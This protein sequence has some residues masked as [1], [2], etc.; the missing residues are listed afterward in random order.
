M[1]K[2]KIT[3]ML[4]LLLSLSSFACT[5]YAD[6][7]Q[8]AFLKDMSE[9]LAKRWSYDENEDSMTRQEFVEY[10][11]KLVDEEYSRLNKY[12]DEEF[13]D[14]KFNILAHAYIDAINTQKES[15]NYYNDIEALYDIEWQSGY[16]IRAL[17]IPTFFDSYGLIADEETVKEF[18]GGI[19][20]SIDLSSQSNTISSTNTEFEIYNNEGITVYVTGTETTEYSKIINLRIQNLN[21][22]DLNIMTKDAQLVINGNMISSSLYAEVKSGKIS[23][24]KIELYND[25]LKNAGIDKLTDISFDLI[26][27]DSSTYDTLFT[28]DQI[29]LT[30]DDEDNISARTVYTDKETIRQVQE[31]LNSA[32]YDC[33]SA[34]GVPGKKTNSAILQFERDHG[35]KENTDITP[36]LLLVLQECIQE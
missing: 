34:D 30:I 35:L 1:K 33:G 11:T 17:V 23:N 29:N 19:S 27:C 7:L 14:Y 2:K 5:A 8:D 18:R 6:D 24:T 10:R 32:G 31:L 36:E 12:K 25:D 20:Y 15:L 22:H 13:Q 16:N 26:F 21:H 28:S 3:I 9:G 4:G